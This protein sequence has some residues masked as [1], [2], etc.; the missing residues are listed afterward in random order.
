MGWF[1]YGTPE[2][3]HLRKGVCLRTEAL[4]EELQLVAS[5]KMR[6][7]ETLFI[8]KIS[9]IRPRGQVLLEFWSKETP[10]T[11]ERYTVFYHLVD[12]DPKWVCESDIGRG[13]KGE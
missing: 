9:E 6:E 11:M 3:R 4:P 10:N 7:N 2:R 5:Q 13:Y 8:V 1:E 12:E